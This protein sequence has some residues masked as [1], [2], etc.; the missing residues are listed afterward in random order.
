MLQYI[1]LLINIILIIAV[2][3]IIFKL[4]DNFETFGDVP[5]NFGNDKLSFVTT[6]EN[7]NMSSIPTQTVQNDINNLNDRISVF[8]T[9]IAN[10]AT[11]PSFTKSISVPGLTTT[12]TITGGTVNSSNSTISG[13]AT[14]GTATIKNANITTDNVQNLTISNSGTLNKQ[15]I[16]HLDMPLT[17]YN[18]G[19]WGDSGGHGQNIGY[20]YGSGDNYRVAWNGNGG[21][22]SSDNQANIQFILRKSP[23]NG[24]PDFKP[25]A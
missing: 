4:Y 10:A 17:I 14:I 3:F 1:N 21:D 22:G 24:L 11:A 15:P 19:G 7:G 18:T 12:G 20:L 25:T 5:S 2:I 23:A 8:E 9:L 6:D 13:T 16:V